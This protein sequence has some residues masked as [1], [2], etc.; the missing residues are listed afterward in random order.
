MTHR[1]LHTTSETCRRCDSVLSTSKD[2]AV[3]H[4]S[5][6]QP[7]PEAN[8][9]LNRKLGNHNLKPSS[10]DSLRFPSGLG[11]LEVAVKF[12]VSVKRKEL[13]SPLCLE[14]KLNS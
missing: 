12:H 4:R 10:L 7:L 2:L 6:H 3:T 8:A 5:L 13:V 1:S 11:A 9:S 14:V